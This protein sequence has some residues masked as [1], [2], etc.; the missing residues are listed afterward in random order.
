M[1]GAPTDL[2]A[3]EEMYEVAR[4]NRD[5]ATMDQIQDM[6]NRLAGQSIHGG[7]KM[8]GAPSMPGTGHN[9]A[10]AQTAQA[11]I[12]AFRSFSHFATSHQRLAL[13]DEQSC[14]VEMALYDAVTDW[15]KGTPTNT[16][17][18]IPTQYVKRTP[19]LPEKPALQE[20]W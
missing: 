3:L 16:L 14:I 15:Y 17:D 5:Q 4:M 6:Y 11:F 13:T 18:G 12:N 1:P 9:Q 20:T 19:R 2:K 8:G 10:P 7:G